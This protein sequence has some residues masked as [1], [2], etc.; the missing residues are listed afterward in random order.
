MI[1]IP[2]AAAVF[3]FKLKVIYERYLSYSTKTRALG[4]Q[5]ANAENMILILSILEW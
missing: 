1:Q 5:S 4:D 2:S 3:V